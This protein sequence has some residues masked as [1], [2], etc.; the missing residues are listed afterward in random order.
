MLDLCNYDGP[1]GE[2]ILIIITLLFYLWVR[3]Y[4]SP[5]RIRYLRVGISGFRYLGYNDHCSCSYLRGIRANTILLPS[6]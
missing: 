1:K 2:Y 3:T 5:D 6:A 4:C